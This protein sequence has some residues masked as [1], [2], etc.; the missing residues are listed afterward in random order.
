VKFGDPKG[1]EIEVCHLGNVFPELANIFMLDARERQV[2]GVRPVFPGDPEWLEGFVDAA[3]ELR[4]LRTRIHGRKE[5]P[6]IVRIREVAEVGNPNVEGRRRLHMFESV[7]QLIQLLFGPLTDELTGDVQILDGGPVQRRQRPQILEHTRQVAQ[8]VRRNIDTREQ[9]HCRLFC[10]VMPR[11]RIVHWRIREAQ[12]LL[13]A[14]RGCGCSIEYDDVD[15]P[16][17]ARLIRANPPDALV[18]DL[19]C[20][21]SHGREAAVYLRRTKYARHIP[22]IFV[23]GEAEKVESIRR[24]LPDAIYATRRQLCAKIKAAC[25]KKPAEP[26]L[27][28][29]MEE[30]YAGRTLAQKLGIKAGSRVALID[31]PRN[32]AALLGEL[33]EGVEL[34][35]EDALIEDID[36]AAAVTLWFADSMRAYAGGLR[37][38]SRIAGQTRLWVIWRKGGASELTSN[39]IRRQGIEAGLVDY[40]IC[41]LGEHWSGMAF[42]LKK[43]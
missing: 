12:P 5:S 7:F 11:V 24:L 36:Q 32:Y 34:I 43:S 17:L 37:R 30:R 22:L 23:D 4:Q 13:E 14:A 16:A 10:H 42:A 15:F 40:K 20:L 27:P 29:S 26:V 6:R 28:P 2:R 35:E 9:P 25:A 3:G 41:A 31:P 38:A 19:T 33:P 8:H 1:P 21:P 39:L 18:I